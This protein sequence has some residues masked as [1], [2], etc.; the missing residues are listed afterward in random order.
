MNCN[1]K[2]CL[3]SHIFLVLASSMT[4]QQQY[5]IPST[6]I[7]QLTK[8]IFSKRDLLRSAECW[9]LCSWISTKHLLP[10]LITRWECTVE[11]FETTW[12]YSWLYMN[13]MIRFCARTKTIFHPLIIFVLCATICICVLVQ[14][15]LIRSL[16][17]QANF[18]SEFTN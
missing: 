18:I 7:K 12:L 2:I 10:V 9:A 8:I 15:G 11:W 4:E 6:L 13:I 5:R 16:V 3:Y 17:K 1:W 14:S